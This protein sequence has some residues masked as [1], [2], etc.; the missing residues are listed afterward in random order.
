MIFIKYLYTKK[1]S[2]T[3]VEHDKYIMRSFRNYEDGKM[4]SN[5]SSYIVRLEVDLPDFDVFVPVT[6][7]DETT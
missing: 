7:N 2:S 1:I 3:Y 4:N 5:G 6:L